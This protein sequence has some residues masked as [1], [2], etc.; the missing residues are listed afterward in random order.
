MRDFVVVS[1]HYTRG[2][3]FKAI[4]AGVEKL[5]KT[6][7]TITI[8][9]L[10]PLDEFHIGG[11]IA[12]RSFLDQ[13]SIRPADEV[14]DVGCGIGGAS[15]FAA[16]TYGCRVTGVD[17]TLEYV[18]TGNHLC[19]WVGLERRVTLGQGNVLALDLPDSTFDKAFMLH[20]AMNIPDKAALAREVWRLLKPG[21][22][23]GIY[24]IMR[25]GDDRLVFPVP[26]ATVAEASSLA[27]PLEYRRALTAAGFKVLGERN[28]REFALEFFDR[29]MAESA[30]GLRR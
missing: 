24:D 25:T 9:D 26:W 13:M 8:E 29:L 22:I 30:R 3:L 1:D 11:R 28:R 4:C 5:G 12:T 15:R 14:F 7:E 17:L 16:Q 10:A 23:F 21:G 2:D 18:E 27:S 20:V 6:P 19:A